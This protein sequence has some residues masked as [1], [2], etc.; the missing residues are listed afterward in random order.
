MKTPLLSTLLMLLASPLSAS[1]DI[2]SLDLSTSFGWEVEN[3]EDDVARALAAGDAT[4]FAMGGI[5][6]TP[7]EVPVELEHIVTSIHAVY[8]G[9]TIMP[10]SDEEAVRMRKQVEYARAYNR[11]LLRALTRDEDYH[12]LGAV[13]SRL[14]PMTQ[15]AQELQSVQDV[16]AIE[17]YEGVLEKMYDDSPRGRELEREA[18]EVF[19]P[20]LSEKYEKLGM[21]SVS[22][23]GWR[24]HAVKFPLDATSSRDT[25][26]GEKILITA[27]ASSI[28]QTID[29]A[30][31]LLAIESEGALSWGLMSLTDDDDAYSG[32]IVTNRANYRLVG[33]SRQ[34]YSGQLLVEVAKPAKTLINQTFVHALAANPRAQHVERR[35]LEVLEAWAFR[36][37]MLYQLPRA[38]NRDHVN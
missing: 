37:G 10:T 26:G 5:A 27:V 32:S 23:G 2:R 17:A 34:P 7:F 21:Y 3:V 4:F 13:V 24:Y 20:D 1:A 25:L 30:H 31:V 16:G 6:C 11:A 12:S 38:K 19:A 29:G 35:H 8:C 36:A 14:P 28:D 15:V 9:C 18:M 33:A 22:F